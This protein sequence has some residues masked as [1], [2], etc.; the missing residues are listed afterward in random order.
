MLF[1][2]YIFILLFFPC[3]LVV[4]FLIGRFSE[5]A[6]AAW[7]TVASLAF[8]MSW[9]WDLIFLL[10]ASIFFNYTS[11]ILIA[12]FVDMNRNVLAKW[13]TVFAVTAN[14]I[15]LAYF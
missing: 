14:L 2:S 6:A 15:C 4:F 13:I 7:L 11:G 1:N 3:V 8:Y 12:R 10:L 9:K 5:F